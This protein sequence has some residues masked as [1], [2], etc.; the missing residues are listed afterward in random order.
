MRLILI[1]AFLVLIFF[2]KLACA[3]DFY[4]IDDGIKLCKGTKKHS[5]IAASSLGIY[6]CVYK[7]DTIENT[8]FEAVKLCN[9]ATPVL[10][11]SKVK[12]QIFWR[13]GQIVDRKF[14]SA[15]AREFKVPV[16]IESFNGETKEKIEYDGF[17]IAG[18]SRTSSN[19]YGFTNIAKV[20]LADGKEICVGTAAPTEIATVQYFDALCLGNIHLRGKFVV[21]GLVKVGGYFRA[22]KIDADLSNPPHRMHIW[23]P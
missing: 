14:Y 8:T 10:L 4:W 23:T 17:L 6:H 12:C 21:R 20:V 15:M 3:Q 5:A 16:K 9:R 1:N 19:G 13:D 18:K 7:G 22:A 2:T 11:R